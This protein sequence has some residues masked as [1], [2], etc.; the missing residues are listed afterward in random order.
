MQLGQ[1]WQGRAL[2]DGESAGALVGQPFGQKRGCLAKEGE[3]ELRAAA[4]LCD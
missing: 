3:A 1:S 2:R 4:A